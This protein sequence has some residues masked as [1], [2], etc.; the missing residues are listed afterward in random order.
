[1]LTLC[2][3]RIAHPLALLFI[4]V[5][6]LLGPRPVGAQVL[7]SGPV[8]AAAD[9]RE[10]QDLSGPW[11]WSIDPYRDGQAG[12]HGGEP[13]TGHR[14]YW[15][16]DVAQARIADPLALYEYD[17][18]AAPIANLP[19][20]WLTHSAPMR[21]YQ[22]L[23]WYQRRFDAEAEPGKRAF[24]RF[25]AANYSADVWLNGHR[26]G[27]HEGGF[28]PFA[29]EVTGLLRK[30]GNRLVVGV[31]STR[32]DRDVPPPVTDWET[33]G[34]ITRE[35]RLLTL[36]DTFVD[37]AWIGLTTNGAIHADIRLDGSGKA[38]LPVKVKIP[39]LGIEARGTADS[40]GK[41]SLRLRAPRRIRHWSPE[42]PRLY[43]VEITAG[44]DTWQD[45]IGFR[46]ITTRG[47][48]ILLNGSPIFLRGISVHE[49]ELGADPARR[50]TDAAAQALLKQAKD[51]LHANFVRLAH[52]PHSETM[53]RA[54]DRMGLI[55]WSEIPVYW[56]IAFDDPEVL[57][58]TRRMLSEMI[59]R[60]RNRVSIALW[61]IGNETPTSDGRNRFMAQLANDV[62]ALDPNRLV[63][64][65][66]LTE[67]EQR[68]GRPFVTISDPLA[69][70]VDVLAVNTYFGWYGSDRLEDIG[71]LGWDLPSDK[72]F[73]FSEFGA[74]A[75]FGLHADGPPQKFSEEYQADYYRATLAM[76]GAIPTLAGM[77]PWIL[78]DF[79]SPRRQL[80]GVQDG[81]NRKGLISETGERKQAFA[82]LADWYSKRETGE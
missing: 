21:H 26:L 55:V 80:P 51:G 39:E 47:S 13:G 4:L 6:A 37:D 41:L 14:R 17:M 33:Y 53:V 32:T 50:M 76:A 9:L 49:E 27:R 68:D 23:V 70:A 44:D 59:L 10:G 12:F 65:A 56:R 29:F 36:P 30:S 77:S 74:G 25:G 18:D 71:S 79:R 67:R 2:L 78:K 48:Q 61:S 52:Y 20:S 1:M 8:L 66:L 42:H 73:M 3:G 38:G 40:G 58:K 7:P 57:E 35:V 34:G 11:N 72:P 82:V 28:T 15:D 69:Q 62:R 24:L 75:K 64:A 5:A 43:R 54:A 22:G 19:S 81:W 60:D 16:T 45:L 46:T 31:D 63:T